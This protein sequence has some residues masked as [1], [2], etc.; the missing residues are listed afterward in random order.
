M[1]LTTSLIPSQ[2]KLG[3][4]P[5]WHPEEQALYWVDIHKKLVERWR[6]KSGKRKTWHFPSAVTAL[7]INAGGGFTVTS[8]KHFGL[9]DGRS[10][11]IKTLTNP[12]PDL[13][14]NRF[15]DGAVGPNGC[16]WAGTMC[17]QVDLDAPPPGS[18]YR[19]DGTLV[20][21]HERDL[22]IS[23][24]LGWSPD[25]KYFYLTDSPIRTIY[26]YEY[27]GDRGEIGN[28]I[29]WIHSQDERGVPDG[30]AVD[31]EGCVWSAQWGGWK[32]IRYD[33]D[34]VKMEE[35]ELPV[36]HP[37]SC[38]FGG[39]EM[40]DLFI[41]SAWTALKEDQRASQPLAGD[42]F[43]LELDVRGQAPFKAKF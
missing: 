28:R 8:V 35:I 37:T 19:F 4:G 40:K 3:E 24:G 30:M 38:A 42:I 10:E 17:E 13:P 26:R 27:D 41:T 11:R 15:N 23:N 21:C 25:Q 34:G 6:P 20:V 5:L 18:F 32:V 1:K 12:E 29:V 31:A 7:G 9:W 39:A 33:P 16:F 2:N 43:L 22:F 14:K 36:A